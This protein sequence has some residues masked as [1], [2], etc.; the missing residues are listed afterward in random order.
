MYLEKYNIYLCE[1]SSVFFDLTNL[2]I[3]HLNENNYHKLINGEYK[4]FD[5]YIKREYKNK[6]TSFDINIEALKINVS[7]ICNLACEYCYA[8]DG[9]Y[10]SKGLINM[11]TCERIT[12]IINKCFPN[13]DSISFFGGEPTLNYEAMKYFCNK[14]PNFHFYMQTNGILLNDERTQLL[15]NQYNINVTLSVDG[16]KNQHDKYRR[17]KDDK[18]TYDTIKKN[19]LDLNSEGIVIQNAQVTKTSPEYSNEY[20]AEQIYKDFN[21]KNILIKNVL[22]SNLLSEGIKEINVNNTILEQ[23]KNIEENKGYFMAQDVKRIL[24]PL[25]SKNSE[26]KYFCEAARKYLQIDIN[27]DIYPCHLML[28]RKNKIGS[29]FDD[30]QSIKE[31][32]YKHAAKI[33]NKNKENSQNCQG[34][35][36]RYNC[37]NCLKYK[38]NDN[39]YEN[40]CRVKQ[41][42]TVFVLEWFAKNLNKIEYFRKVGQ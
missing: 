5:D 40:F 14:F 7:Q 12:Y 4:L 18:P 17:T 33:H 13:I 42:N 34:C 9:E 23:L 11:S 26:E 10:H 31:E 15:I 36:A 35:I 16:T 8:G 20:L 27:G 19:L 1:D 32:V 3:M 22:N 25:L 6:D 41:K 38:N 39:H 21:I 2:K 30:A 29:V 24:W 28:S 37:I